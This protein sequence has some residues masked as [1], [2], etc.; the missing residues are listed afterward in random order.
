MP[1]NIID[2]IDALTNGDILSVLGEA[3]DIAKRSFPALQGID[4]F[5]DGVELIGD[6]TRAW[7]AISKM[8]NFGD[9]VIQGVLHIVRQK[10]GGLLGKIKWRNNSTGA[11]II[12]IP[13]NEASTFFEDLIDLFPDAVIGNPTHPNNILYDLES[14]VKIEFQPTSSTTQTPTVTLKVGSYAVKLRLT[15]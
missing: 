10:T 11:E 8:R 5:F 13:G 3:L 9:E 1:Q 4:A 14:G 6:G 2:A 15:P 12:G 7:R